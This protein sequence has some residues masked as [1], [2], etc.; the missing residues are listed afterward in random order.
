MKHTKAARIRAA[1][2]LSKI[3]SFQNRKPSAINGAEHGFHAVF[4]S[5]K[6]RPQYAI[7]LIHQQFRD[8]GGVGCPRGGVDFIGFRRIH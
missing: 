7:S 1:F 3:V 6:M 8:G 2:V 4:I 5:V